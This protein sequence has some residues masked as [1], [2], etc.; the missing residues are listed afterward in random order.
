MPRRAAGIWDSQELGLAL[1]PG[2]GCWVVLLYPWA[3][4]S[5]S[6]GSREV[7]L[8][9]LHHLRRVCL[10]QGRFCGE[11]GENLSEVGAQRGLVS[12]L[13]SLARASASSSCGRGGSSVTVQPPRSLQGAVSG[14]VQ[15]TDRLMKELR[16][17]YR[18]PSFKG[19]KCGEGGRERAAG[20]GGLSL[21]SGQHQ[22]GLR[23]G[24]FCSVVSLRGG[25]QALGCCGSKASRAASCG[26]CSPSVLDGSEEP[27]VGGR[28]SETEA[29]F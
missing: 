22:R 15:A 10:G 5:C 17:I 1:G 8:L 7:F 13:G 26:V 16:D 6:R 4:V 23:A 20:C 29:G 25:S 21:R 2:E 18:S 28:A 27:A 19:G 24:S 14:S 9:Q 3:G 11:K 12:R